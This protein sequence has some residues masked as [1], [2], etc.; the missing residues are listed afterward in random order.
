MTDEEEDSA[1]RWNRPNLNI[2]RGRRRCA[3][4]TTNATGKSILI[5]IT[6]TARDRQTTVTEIVHGGIGTT[7]EWTVE[8]E[9]VIGAV[10]TGDHL[11]RLAMTETEVGIILQSV[12]LL[13]NLQLIHHGH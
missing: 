12:K 3:G 8:E 7:I 5:G 9:D 13:T 2:G 6:E 4:V 10:P 1:V 11:R